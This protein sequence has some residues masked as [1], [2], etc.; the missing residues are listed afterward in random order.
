MLSD[1]EDLDLSIK[2]V[3]PFL[4][5]SIFDEEEY[6]NQVMYKYEPDNQYES[7]SRSVI[8]P[9]EEETSE[10]EAEE[11]YEFEDGF[12]NEFVDEQFEEY[13]DEFEEFNEDFDYEVELQREDWEQE[14][15]DFQLEDSDSLKEVKSTMQSILKAKTPSEKRINQLKQLFE[16]KVPLF[17]SRLIL[18]KLINN[19]NEG[20]LL[21]KCVPQYSPRRR[22]LRLLYWRTKGADITKRGEIFSRRLKKLRAKESTKLIWPTKKKYWKE[23]TA[24]EKKVIRSSHASATIRAEAMLIA[25]NIYAKQLDTPAAAS[26]YYEKAVGLIRN[27]QAY[28]SLSASDRELFIREITS[29]IQMIKKH[30]LQQSEKPTASSLAECRSGAASDYFMSGYMEDAVAVFKSILKIDGLKLDNF[31]RLHALVKLGDFYKESVPAAA[32]YY[33]EKYL[34]SGLLHGDSKQ[35]LKKAI[36]R[37]NKRVDSP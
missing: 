13:K 16:E 27:G 36:T 3:T 15:A 1:K 18:R 8:E 9:A 37:L 34:E 12:D 2:F 24:Y 25:A 26:V 20:R 19:T 33:Y 22:L 4:N 7:Q 10:A 5:E 17:D 29:R 11:Y 31:E 28:S 23:M 32:L 14:W 35:S 21:K 30:L 6:E